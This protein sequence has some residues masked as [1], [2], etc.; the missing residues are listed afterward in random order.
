MI[1]EQEVDEDVE[2]EEGAEEGDKSKEKEDSKEGESKAVWG[3][4]IMSA[5]LFLAFFILF[6]FI[7]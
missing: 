4:Q 1:E 2:E 5:I 7:K 6:Y 3:R